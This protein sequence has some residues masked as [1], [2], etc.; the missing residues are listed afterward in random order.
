MDILIFNGH[1]NGAPELIECMDCH[2]KPA[3]SKNI[4]C[5]H[6]LLCATCT[7]N[8]RERNGPTCPLSTCNKPSTI[9]VTPPTKIL[10]D[11]CY[12]D[13]G[14]SYTVRT[15]DNCTHHVCVECMVKNVRYSLN[16]KQDTF[17]SPKLPGVHC[18]MYG[19][20]AGCTA[21]VGISRINITRRVSE[22]R[23]NV[24]TSEQTPLTRIE[25][26]RYERFSNE[27]IIPAQRRIF[28]VN[29]ECLGKD[30]DGNR[31]VLDTELDTKLDT[32][33]SES[34][35]GETK[36]GGRALTEVPTFAQQRQSIQDLWSQYIEYPGNDRGMI[37]GDEWYL[38][39]YKWWTQWKSVTHYVQEHTPEANERS[40]RHDPI[41][42][43]EDAPPSIDNTNLIAEGEVIDEKFA[44]SV[45]HFTYLKLKHKLEHPLQEKVV[46]HILVPEEVWKALH[47][48]Y[49]GGPALMRRVVISPE[50]K[51]QGHV[52]QLWRPEGTVKKIG[53][54]FPEVTQ[55]ADENRRVCC[56]IDLWPKCTNCNKSCTDKKRCSHCNSIVYC[57]RKCQVMHWPLHKIQCNLIARQKKA[58]LKVKRKATKREA[59]LKIAKQK[60]TEMKLMKF[61]CIYCQT[62]MCR[63]C[64][65]L[66]T[67][68]SIP[69]HE[70]LLCETAGI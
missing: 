6:T 43:T 49:G 58:L 7:R 41:D 64:R 70:G 36:S 56:Q 23:H 5:N 69:W 35:E 38:I 30:V 61:E 67:G 51:V 9:F 59:K 53:F 21:R 8:H 29:K 34:C 28:C 60:K 48:W 18:P 55:G 4:P 1:A 45:H 13:W 14:P 50:A 10:C 54:T 63:S 2:A 20:S 33:L 65:D 57:S 11:L 47:H 32:H 27:G 40:D 52:G 26:A 16:N 42:E 62:S 17:D 31:Y 68:G 22:A 12:E 24:N 15:S 39:D 44:T 66:R 19:S 46:E 37:P 3:A 25:T